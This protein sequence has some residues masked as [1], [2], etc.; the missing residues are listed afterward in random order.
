MELIYLLII[1][2]IIFFVIFYLN[3]YKE[4]FLISHSLSVN[5]NLF[6][7]DLTST[8][9]QKV[10]MPTGVFNLNQYYIYNVYNRD[11][12]YLTRVE[13]SDKD[14]VKEKHYLFIKPKPTRNEKYYC[15]I[16]TTYES[17][18]DVKKDMDIIPNVD[19]LSSG[20]VKLSTDI[21]INKIT[22][23]FFTDNNF[24][25]RKHRQYIDD[26]E[27]NIYSDEFDFNIHKYPTNNNDNLYIIKYI[28]KTT[29]SRYYLKNLVNCKEIYKDNE[30]KSNQSI[31]SWSKN[32]DF[33]INSD[34]NIYLTDQEEFDNDLHNNNVEL[35]LME[36]KPFYKKTD[37]FEHLIFG[38]DD[39][40]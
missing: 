27:E 5:K 8:I 16:F 12:Y 14:V 32:K 37:N 21:S 35:Y 1:L 30:E 22:T 20:K 23:N 4:N 7:F 38:N 3:N 15:D 17:I 9:N 10:V 36:I 18:N 33:S 25:L 11:K 6:E 40:N 24:R 28:D 34:I 29:N 26:E 31:C 19:M 39:C 13:I 2:I